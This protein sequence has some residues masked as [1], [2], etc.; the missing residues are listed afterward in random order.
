[1]RLVQFVCAN[2]NTLHRLLKLKAQWG[3]HRSREDG[4]AVAV[5]PTTEVETLQRAHSERVQEG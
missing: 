2:K 5:S 3:L 4:A 1:L